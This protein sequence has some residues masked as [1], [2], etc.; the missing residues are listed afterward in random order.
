MGDGN[1]AATNNGRGHIVATNASMDRFAEILSRQMDRPVVNQTGLQGV[2]NLTLQWTPDSARPAN[3][4]NGA[5]TEG[6]SIFTAIQEQLGLRL[7]AQKVPVDVL[8]ID[9]AERPDAN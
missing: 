4:Q 3:P 9:H 6:P 5:A 8:V 2:F 1:G 7:R